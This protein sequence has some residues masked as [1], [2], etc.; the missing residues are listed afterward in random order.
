M[1]NPEIPPAQD[2]GRGAFAGVPGME[3]AVHTAGLLTPGRN[4]RDRTGQAA[5]C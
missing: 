2:S 4:P 3:T 1:G 5:N